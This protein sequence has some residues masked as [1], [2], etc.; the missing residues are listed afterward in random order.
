MNNCYFA[1]RSDVVRIKKSLK[2]RLL[3]TLRFID[4]VRGRDDAEFQCRL[5]NRTQVT[6]FVSAVERSVLVSVDCK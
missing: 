6:G 1:V 3:S 5:V 2:N 4:V